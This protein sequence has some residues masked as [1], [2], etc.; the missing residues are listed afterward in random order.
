MKEE[1]TYHDFVLLSNS[2]VPPHSW[3]Q[4]FIDLFLTMWQEASGADKERSALSRF[5]EALVSFRECLKIRHPNIQLS[6][7]LEL[8]SK[9]ELS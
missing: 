3:D 8:I 2:I 4:L 1:P 9:N 6:L 7:D 5:G